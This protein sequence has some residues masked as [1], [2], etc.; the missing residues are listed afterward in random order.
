MGAR[1]WQSPC[2]SF[3]GGWE[4]ILLVGVRGF[5]GAAKRQAVS[6]CARFFWGECGCCAVLR[7]ERRGE[8]FGWLGWLIVVIGVRR[9]IFF[10]VLNHEGDTGLGTAR[11]YVGVFV[12]GVVWIPTIPKAGSW[13]FTFYGGILVHG[14]EVW[15]IQAH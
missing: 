14:L 12:V 4:V 5:W 10:M 13:G 9:V 8:W 2:F 6:R 11:L 3:G 7:R 15:V 1:G